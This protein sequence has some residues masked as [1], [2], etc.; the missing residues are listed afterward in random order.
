MDEQQQ[1]ALTQ[2]GEAIGK[3]ITAFAEAL[4]PVV[5][6]LA[7]AFANAYTQAQDAYYYRQAT[8]L[9]YDPSRIVHGSLTSDVLL[10]PERAESLRRE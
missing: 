5:T 7:T 4:M 10:I 9:D 3:M 6:T 2:L 8:G 1:Q